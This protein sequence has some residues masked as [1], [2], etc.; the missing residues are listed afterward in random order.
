[1]A[2]KLTILF[3]AKKL[4]ESYQKKIL[5]SLEQVRKSQR[6]L[7]GLQTKIAE[8]KEKGLTSLLRASEIIKNRLKI[9]QEEAD[10]IKQNIESLIAI[11]IDADDIKKMWEKI[12]PHLESCVE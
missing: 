1:M 10:T 6:S 7:D 5:E 12:L 11:L 3:L 4:H 9:T 2:Q 8:A